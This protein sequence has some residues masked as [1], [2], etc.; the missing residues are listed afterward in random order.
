M[1]PLCNICLF[2]A[3]SWLLSVLDFG[4]VVFFLFWLFGR[5]M[6]LLLFLMDSPARESVLPVNFIDALPWINGLVLCGF[7]S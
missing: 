4:R 1:F 6:V 3:Y 2:L 7:D 5:V